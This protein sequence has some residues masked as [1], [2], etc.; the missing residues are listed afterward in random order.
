[1]EPQTL[2]AEAAVGK[3]FLQETPAAQA[4]QVLS[5]SE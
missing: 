3:M 5:S 1:M 2:V 4:A